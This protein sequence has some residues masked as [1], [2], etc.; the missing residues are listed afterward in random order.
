MTAQARTFSRICHA[1]VLTVLIL[2]GLNVASAQAQ[3]AGQAQTA[4]Q[5]QR[6]TA[7]LDQLVAPIA[8]YPDAVLAQIFMA[9]TYPLEVIEAARWSQANPEIK[10]QALEDAMQQQSWDP[11]VKAL[12]EE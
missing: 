9:S 10:G 1:I 12:T 3:T 4:A 8:L 5:P 7:Q 2:V 6:T 11:S